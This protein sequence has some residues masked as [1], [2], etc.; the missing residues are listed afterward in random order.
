[1]RPGARQ[2][3]GEAGR[4]GGP[5]QGLEGGF[6]ARGGAGW[7]ASETS[8][9][10][11]SWDRSQSPEKAQVSGW[12]TRTGSSSRG[13]SL[14]GQT[15]QR[16]GRGISSPGSRRPSPARHSRR[17]A[18]Y[19]WTPWPP[20]PAQNRSGFPRRPASSARAPPRQRRL[21]SLQLPGHF[22][23]GKHEG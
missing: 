17:T 10:R 4:R 19:C 15:R 5:S 12:R 3:R 9:P 8:A 23:T 11:Y 20:H 2:G 22:L 1:M 21:G 6:S 7:P 16:N 18:S 14:L 13:G